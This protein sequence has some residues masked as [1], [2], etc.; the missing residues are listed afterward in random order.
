MEWN[1]NFTWFYCN[2]NYVPSSYFKT[3]AFGHRWKVKNWTTGAATNSISCNGAARCWWCGSCCSSCWKVRQ[4]QLWVGYMYA[5]KGCE[6]RVVAPEVTRLSIIVL[7]LELWGGMNKSPGPSGCN[8]I[9]ASF[10]RW[11]LDGC[12][13]RDGEQQNFRTER[14]LSKT[15]ALSR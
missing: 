11:K 9:A 8:G 5:H 12:D 10:C 6:I 1:S 4:K 15:L 7:A 14:C 13:I 2:L 3:F